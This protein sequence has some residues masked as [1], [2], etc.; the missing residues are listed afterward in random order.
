[1]ISLCE[2]NLPIATEILSPTAYLYYDDL[3]SWGAIG[4]RTVDSQPHRE[5]AS[6]IPI[7]LGFKN[8]ISGNIDIAINGVAFAFRKQTFIG[9][10]CNGDFSIIHSAGNP[11]AHLILRGGQDGPNYSREH[12]SKAEKALVSLNFPKN[13][14]IDCSH[15]N[16][17]KNYMKQEAVFNDVLDQKV[18]GNNSI[19]GVMI[20][21][22]LEAGNQ[23]ISTTKTNLMY[24]C[25][26]TDGC[27]NWE[28]TEAIIKKAYRKLDAS[29]TSGD[30]QRKWMGENDS[31]FSEFSK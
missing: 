31:S 18:D 1:M 4:A 9:I 14:I 13:I 2:M 26:V 25:S 16:S 3:L 10:N 17:S 30:S 11:Y 27:L 8:S 20:E 21:S 22:F 6:S 28:S 23:S 24:G 5:I 15:G 29:Y 7:P 19:V 12:I